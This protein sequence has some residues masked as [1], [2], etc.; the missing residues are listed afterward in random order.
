MYK[1]VV[2]DMDFVTREREV[3]RFWAE[4]DI[5]KK[6]FAQNKGK[7]RFVFYEGP[8]T[9]NGKPHVGHII[10]R[11]MKDLFPRYHSMKGQKVLRKAGWDTHGLPV[12]L[13]V[14][15]LIGI[16]GKAVPAAF[17]YRHALIP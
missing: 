7:D 10:T 16:N 17:N 5:M 6:S 9:A 11:A 4:N 12:E 14:E 15:K 8:P 1:K 3:S 2:S 13:E